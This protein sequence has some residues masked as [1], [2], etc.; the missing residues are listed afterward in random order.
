[1]HHR[2][3]NFNSCLLHFGIS[4]N[5]IY[6]F[7]SQSHSFR[8][9]LYRIDSTIDRRTVYVHVPASVYILQLDSAMWCCQ[10]QHGPFDR[11]FDILDNNKAYNFTVLQNLS[12]DSIITFLMRKLHRYSREAVIQIFL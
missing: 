5:N 11:Q 2:R 3:G 1:M 10:L 4:H 9:K 7:Y 8:Y 6:T 12:F